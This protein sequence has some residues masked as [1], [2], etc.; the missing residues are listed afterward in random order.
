MDAK[1]MTS[2]EII[3]KIMNEKKTNAHAF[4]K[5]LGVSY[6]KI[7][8]LYNG[9]TKT[10]T[11]YLEDVMVSHGVNRQFIQTGEGAILN[12]QSSM[13]LPEVNES[14]DF[15]DAFVKVVSRLNEKI[16][17]KEITIQQLKAIIAANESTIKELSEKLGETD[18]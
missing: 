8:E 3:V 7:F 4:A 15:V 1:K 17:D 14:A 10:I 9:R 16:K 12:E 11:Q 13:T 18:E 6:G 5:E 2:Q